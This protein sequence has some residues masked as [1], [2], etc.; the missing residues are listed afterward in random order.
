MNCGF[1]IAA[2]VTSTDKPAGRGL[3]E[4]PS[5]VKV[6][7]NQHLIPVLQPVSMKDPV[8][9]DQLKS[10]KPDLQIVIAFRM[11]PREVWEMSPLGTFN[12]HA[13]ILPQYRGAAPINRAI[14]NGEKETGVTTFMLNEQ[15]DAGKI[16]FSEKVDIGP[17]ETAGELH[18][19]LMITGAGLVVKTVKEIMAGNTFEIQQNSLISDSS[20]LK[21]APKIFKEDCRIDWHQEVNAIHNLIR[22]LSPYPG[23]FTEIILEDGTRQ[24]LKIFRAFPEHCD[25]SGLQGAVFTDRRTYIKIGAKNGFI[26]LAELQMPGRKAMNS[27]DFLRGYGHLFSETPVK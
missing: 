20:V 5:P 27:G 10:I 16:L 24:A 15:I 6:F 18:D 2:V 19:R 13:S 22:G 4:R 9:L 12:L 7:A 3:K 8:F 14:M 25:S 1:D 23:A 11:M 21:P 17:D 26:H